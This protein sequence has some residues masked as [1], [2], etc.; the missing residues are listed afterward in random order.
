MCDGSVERGQF[1]PQ[2]HAKLIPCTG[3]PVDDDFEPRIVSLGVI[4]DG[5]Y[6]LQFGMGVGHDRRDPLHTRY[7]LA[8][9]KTL[10]RLGLV[11]ATT[12]SGG[13]ISIRIRV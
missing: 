1:L 8:S 9:H 3:T 6:V 13:G 10:H 2:D 12:K 11:V 5:S 7:F 4:M